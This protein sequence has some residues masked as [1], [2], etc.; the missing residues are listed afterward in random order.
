MRCQQQRW[1]IYIDFIIIILAKPLTSDRPRSGSSKLDR[2]AAISRWRLLLLLLAGA[3]SP[4]SGDAAAASDCHTASRT[5][6]C[7]YPT[8]YPHST[9]VHP[10]GPLTPSLISCAPL[11]S[12]PLLGLASLIPYACLGVWPHRHRDGSR[13]CGGAV[14]VPPP[15]WLSPP[16]SCAQRPDHL[17]RRR[18]LSPPH[19][20]WVA[21]ISFDVP[22]KR[23]YAS[24]FDMG[25]AVAPTLF[26]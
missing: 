23:S 17:A 15:R 18:T 25:S 10:P 8:Q 26:W 12:P 21:L 20:Y 13:C 9:P 1:T 11:P 19:R 3:A 14:G 5:T 2:T 7:T 24:N 4:A 16:R 6:C 22:L